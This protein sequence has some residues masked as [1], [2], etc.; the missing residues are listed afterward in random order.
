MDF[1][2]ASLRPFNLQ[3]RILPLHGFLGKGSEDEARQMFCQLFLFRGNQIEDLGPEL[4]YCCDKSLQQR[5]PYKPPVQAR[6]VFVFL[7]FYGL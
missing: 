1:R 7:F 6:Y 4:P 3:S 5:K 2:P